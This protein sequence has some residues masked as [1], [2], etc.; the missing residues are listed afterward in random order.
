VYHSGGE[1]AS[2]AGARKT[3]LAVGAL[4]CCTLVSLTPARPADA[5]LAAPGKPSV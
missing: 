2:S 4:L 3:C 1:Q 5:G